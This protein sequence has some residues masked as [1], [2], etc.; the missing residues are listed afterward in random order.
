MN[1]EIYNFKELHEELGSQNTTGSDCEIL[2]HL[3]KRY[4]M[5]T[6]LSRVVGVFAFLLYDTPK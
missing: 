3:Y 1:G 6:A 4:G 5:R 2:I